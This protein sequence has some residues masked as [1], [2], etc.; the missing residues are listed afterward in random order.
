MRFA[1]GSAGRVV[2]PESL[3]HCMVWLFNMA[4]RFCS[5][6]EKRLKRRLSHA[7]KV[8]QVALRASL[9]AGERSAVQVREMPQSATQQV[10]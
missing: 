1:N 9:T 8:Q 6:R 7:R 10:R 3:L 2:W 4:S 5:S